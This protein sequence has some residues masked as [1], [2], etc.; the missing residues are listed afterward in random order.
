MQINFGDI[1]GQHNL[2][3]DYLYEFENVKKFYKHDFR[4]KEEYLK[5]LQNNFRDKQRI[6]K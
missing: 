1:P 2:F 4:N 5:N 6:Q 3:L